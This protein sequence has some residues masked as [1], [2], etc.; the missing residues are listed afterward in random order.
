MVLRSRLTAK[1]SYVDSIGFMSMENSLGKE[2]NRRTVVEVPPGPHGEEVDE[3]DSDKG[4]YTTDNEQPYI[5]YSLVKG[6]W[7]SEATKEGGSSTD[8]P[9]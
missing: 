6:V 9:R 1:P 4:H 7:V 5:W 2:R 8:C 3:G